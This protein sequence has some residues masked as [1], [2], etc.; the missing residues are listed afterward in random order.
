M[1]NIIR[2]DLYRMYKTKSFRICLI[3]VTLLNLAVGPLEKALFNMV[4]DLSDTESLWDNNTVFSEILGAPFGTFDTIAVM[5]SVVWFTHADIADGYIKNIAGQLP[6]KGHTV[7][8]KFCAL[9]VHNAMFTLAAIIGQT[10]GQMIVRKVDFSTGIADAAGDLC[11]R[12]LLLMAMSSLVLFF[13]TAVGARTGGSIIA[14]LWGGGFLSL[15]YSGVDMLFSKLLK[16]DDFQLGDYMP[17]SNFHES[18]DAFSSGRAFIVA[19]VFI[20]ALNVLS[21]N[22]FNKK[23]VK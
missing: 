9:I 20:V 4:A 1:L 23:D 21:I 6:R 15:A 11:I 13:T 3:I 16:M 18:A 2:M 22:V 8:S 14:V 10:I 17:D 19:I 7:I 5:L 12:F